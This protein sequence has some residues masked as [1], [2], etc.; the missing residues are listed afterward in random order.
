MT[1]GREKETRFHETQQHGTS[2][3]IACIIHGKRWIVSPAKPFEKVKML[4]HEKRKSKYRHYEKRRRKRR[5]SEER[6]TYPPFDFVPL[7]R[8]SYFLNLYSFPLLYWLAWL[9]LP[10]GITFGYKSRHS[11]RI[12][13][14]PKTPSFETIIS[15]FF[16][17]R[18]KL[19]IGL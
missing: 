9:P 7:H 4:A 17:T 3:I 16:V 8:L 12:I 11:Y 1:N 10:P 5:K 19:H 6:A 14:D 13:P 18:T 15:F 2:A